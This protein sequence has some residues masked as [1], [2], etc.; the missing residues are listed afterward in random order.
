[1]LFKA[2]RD[3]SQS[4]DI[5]NFLSFR[6]LLNLFYYFIVSSLIPFSSINFLKAFL[7]TTAHFLR[8]FKVVSVKLTAALSSLIKIVS[9]VTSFNSTDIFLGYYSWAILLESIETLALWRGVLIS[10]VISRLNLLSLCWL[11]IYLLEL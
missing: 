1:M 8:I 4:L 2:A 3:S 10:R 6:I 11:I 9:L 7:S 5:W